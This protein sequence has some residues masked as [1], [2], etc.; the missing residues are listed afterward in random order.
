MAVVRYSALSL[1]VKARRL[2][3]VAVLLSFDADPTLP[4]AMG[5]SPYDRALKDH[6]GVQVRNGEAH[7]AC[8]RQAGGGG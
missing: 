1:A 7:E 8:N 6:A 5:I 3:V 2:D 4:D